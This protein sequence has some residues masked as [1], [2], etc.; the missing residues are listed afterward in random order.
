MGDAAHETAFVMRHE[1]RCFRRH[2]LHQRRHPAVT[3][4]RCEIH[5]HPFPDI[6]ARSGNHLLGPA[7]PDPHPPVIRSQMP[8]E[9]T[10]AVMAAM[11]A[12]TLHPQLA[13]GKIDLV[14]EDEDVVIRNLVESCRFGNRQSGTVH[15]GL[16]LDREDFF[17]AEPTFG[18]LR[19]ILVFPA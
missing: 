14:I 16:R 13:G 7:N 17:P 6:D 3:L 11:A 10:N 15:E 9:I 2:R 19:A 8:V 1:K 5:Q 4:C 18:E 12:A